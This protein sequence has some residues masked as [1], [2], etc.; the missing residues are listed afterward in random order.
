MRKLQLSIAMGDY[1]HVRDLLQGDVQ[2]EGVELIV[3]KRRPVEE[4]FYRFT[5]HREWDI[6]EMSFGKYVALA[7]QPGF[8]D[9]LRAIIEAEFTRWVPIH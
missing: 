7:S 9:E 8:P 2:A 4:I 3:A 5:M 1:D 6:S